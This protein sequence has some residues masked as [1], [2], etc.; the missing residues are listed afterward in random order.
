MSDNPPITKTRIFLFVVIIGVFI[1]IAYLIA[2]AFASQCPQGMVYDDKQKKCIPSCVD[3]QVYDP[4][5]NACGCPDGGTLVG[6]QCIQDCSKLGPNWHIC[7]NTC[8]NDQISKCLPDGTICDKD[9]TTWKQTCC[10]DDQIYRPDPDKS[11]KYF[12][13]GFPGTMTTADMIAALNGKVLKDGFPVTPKE[14]T[15]FQ[16]ELVAGNY[17]T[18]ESLIDADKDPDSG[19]W[20]SFKLAD[21]FADILRSAMGLPTCSSCSKD[22]IMCGKKCCNAGEICTGEGADQMCCPADHAHGT[23]CCKNWSEKMQICCADNEIAGDAGC[24]IKCVNDPNVLCNTTEG[25][26]CVEGQYFGKDGIPLQKYSVCK[27]NKACYDQ[28]NYNPPHI[29]DYNK[30][31]LHVCKKQNMPDGPY[32]N[33]ML[34]DISDYNPIIATWQLSKDADPTCGIDDCI[35]V[36]SVQ[37]NISANL[38]GT[39]CIGEI[40]CA[41][42]DGIKGRSCDGLKCPFSGTQQQGQCCFNDGVYNGKICDDGYTCGSDGDSCIPPIV[43]YTCGTDPDYPGLPKCVPDYT[44]QPDGVKYF[45]GSNCDNKCVCPSGYNY[46][47]GEQG[48]PNPE[49]CYKNIF[50]S[51]TAYNLNLCAAKDPVFDCGYGTCAI[52]GTGS[53]SCGPGWS[54]SAEGDCGV[55]KCSVYCTSD[56][57]PE[58]VMYS[59][60]NKKWNK[61]TTKGGCS[62]TKWGSLYN[63]AHAISCTNLT[64]NSKNYAI[65]PPK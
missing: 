33:C 46:W 65:F 54:V 48:N 40:S 2:K 20:A 44:H 12:P 8:F 63:R 56:T 41:G 59:D 42:S 36:N 25:K 21:D 29:I 7:A 10:D 62:G 1:V 64:D 60:A 16:T 55:A 17:T 22:N 23:Q 31:Q 61:C 28:V 11:T 52:G 3:P 13:K 19:V 38:D 4:N 49:G 18:V 58:G 39:S 47:G 27:H 53:G 37:G 45:Q 26:E 14:I 51:L 34:N 30:D 15:D 6:D 5:T 32:A 50:N 43:S 24:S 57:I 9:R 35:A